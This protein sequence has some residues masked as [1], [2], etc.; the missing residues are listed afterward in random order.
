MNEDLQPPYFPGDLP[1][2]EAPAPS[3]LARFRESIGDSLFQISRAFPKLLALRST[4]GA[5]TAFRVL[6]GVVGAGLVVLPLSLWNGWAF[7]PVGLVLFL[8]AVLLPPV[9]RDRGTAKA[10]KQLGAYLMLDGGRAPSVA[11]D[12]AAGE[13]LD[14]NFFLTPTRIWALDDELRPVTVIPVDEIT[15]VT[16]FPEQDDWVLRVS[17]QSNSAEFRF[18]G[19]FAQRRA[20]LAEQG[21]QHLVHSAEQPLAKGTKA[22]AA[23]A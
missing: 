12:T 14:V 16:A 1:P 6:M 3:S 17:W 20:Q 13:S 11:G 18:D 19:L 2:A 8:L 10:I 21:L 4:P 22:R 9:R 5:W 23:S 15:L 7:A